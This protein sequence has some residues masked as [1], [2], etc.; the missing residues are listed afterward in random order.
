[1]C[2]NNVVFATLIRD[3]PHIV[4]SLSSGWGGGTRTPE[5]MD[6]NHVPYQLGDTPP[7]QKKTIEL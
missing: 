7:S 6:Q 5:C 1:M 2:E 3:E 4:Q